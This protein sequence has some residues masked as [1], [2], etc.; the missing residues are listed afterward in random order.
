MI[1]PDIKAVVFDLDGTLYDRRGLP[2]RLVLGILANLYIL[3][4]ERAV[5]KEIAGVYYGSEEAFYEAFFDKIAAKSK[6]S[7]E[8]IRRWYFTRYI[9]R[10]VRLLAKHHHIYGW[11][12]QVMQELRNKGIKIAIFSDY[13][14]VEEKLQAVGFN[15]EW[16][17]YIFDVPSLG[18]IKPCRECFEKVARKL[19]LEPSQIMV[20]GDRDDTDG[21]GARRSGM[22]FLKV[23]VESD[24]AN[25]P[26]GLIG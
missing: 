7:R 21:E 11:V 14:C 24:G 3:G 8:H 26:A 23:D 1:S 15:T 5:R 10:M 20:V 6:V 25:V 13:G 12:P 22:P 16:A 18:G 17:D 9:P 19:G 2:R 4:A